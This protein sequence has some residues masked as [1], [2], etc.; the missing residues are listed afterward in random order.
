MSIGSR[1]ACSKR[2]TLA[3]SGRAKEIAELR[4]ADFSDK[5]GNNSLR[6]GIAAVAGRLQSGALRIVEG[7]C[8]NLLAESGLYRYDET[9]SERLNEAPLDE[10]NHALAALRYLIYGRDARR[11]A[12]RHLGAGQSP[13]NPP[14]VAKPPTD[15]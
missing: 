1:T 8:P 7:R 4:R 9:P 11:L 6:P 10:H 14:L 2:I 12:S 15:E 5:P 3:P 13:D